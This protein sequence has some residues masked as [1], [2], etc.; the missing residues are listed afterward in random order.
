M[1]TALGY[2]ATGSGDRS[3][4]IGF[5]SDASALSTTAVG[6]QAIA[7]HTY[8]TAIGYGAKTTASN[9]L[10]LGGANSSVR[11]GD[12]NSSTA[13]QSGQL[14]T[15][16]VDANG[17]L[18][19]GSALASAQQLA[20]LGMSLQAVAAVSHEQFA[21]LE[22]QVDQLFDLAALDRSEMRRGIAATAAMA[23]PHFPSGPGRTSYASNVAMFRGEVGVSAGLMH[24]I[25]GD[26]PFAITA[27][28]SYGGGSN[29]AVRAG[30]A[31][32]F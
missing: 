5:L 32:E 20:S 13:A 31:G 21:Q 1:E 12:I 9:Q 6:G 28:A 16:T 25:E 8:A 29:T 23:D 30:I 15:V 27:G 10:A 17:T 14:Y 24:R 18:G 7:A 3:T 26:T 2:R 11:I 22:G 19:R 4:A